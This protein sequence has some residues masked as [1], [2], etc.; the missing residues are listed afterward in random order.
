MA[1]NLQDLPS[2]LA[3]QYDGL[4]HSTQFKFSEAALRSFSNI[5]KLREI[6]AQQHLKKQEL[7]Q[8]K[9][10]N[11]HQ[12]AH[13]HCQQI[14]QDVLQQI[15]SRLDQL[16]STNLNQLKRRQDLFKIKLSN[17]R[18]SIEQTLQIEANE[19][20]HKIDFLTLDIKSSQQEFTNI[21]TLEEKE[22]KIEQREKSGFFAGLARFFGTGGYTNHT[23]EIVTPYARV[24]D[25]IEQLTLFA[26]DAILSL[27]KSLTVIIDMQKL[28]KRVAGT[29]IDLFDTEDPD[30]DLLSFKVQINSCLSSYQPPQIVFSADD[31]VNNIVSQFG[32]GSV[33]NNDI[34]QLKRAHKKS[35]GDISKHIVKLA[36]NA[37]KDIDQ[38]FTDMEN[39][40][41]TNLIGQLQKDLADMTAQLNDKENSLRQLSA[42]KHALV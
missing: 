14:Q 41:V 7:L 36:E 38:Y 26:D 42:F 17:G 39:N 22:T 6:M 11:L 16:S 34:E 29:A 21:D 2:D 31:V 28:R 25:S 30:F 15:D 32:S 23:V 13:T 35:I 9:V 33:H 24:Q 19:I 12:G 10:D 3:E 18:K 37:K 20:R 5:I 4:C 40:L 1:E 8:V 27:Q